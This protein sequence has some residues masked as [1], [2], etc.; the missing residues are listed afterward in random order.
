LHYVGLTSKPIFDNTS[1]PWC[2]DLRSMHAVILGEYLAL[3]EKLQA[4]RKSD[5]VINKEEHKLHE[6]QWDW[7]S[8]IVKGRRQADFATSCPRTVELLESL[9]APSLMTSTPFSYCFFSTLHGGSSIAPHY[10]PCNLRLRS[11]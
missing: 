8:Y 9:T 3:R 4:Q 7:N 11:L 10:G 2:D 1:F 5:Y 6:G